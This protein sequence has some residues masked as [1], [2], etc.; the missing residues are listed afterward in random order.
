MQYIH[1]GRMLPTSFSGKI[2]IGHLV[3]SI[4]LPEDI[5]KAITNHY[6]SVRIVLAKFGIS[7]TINAGI[8][9]GSFQQESQQ[10]LT[11]ALET[12]L[13]DQQAAGS[14]YIPIAVRWDTIYSNG[15]HPMSTEAI[16]IKCK[17]EDI[18][19]VTTKLSNLYGSTVADHDPH[20]PLARFVSMAAL[21]SSEPVTAQ[22]IAWQ[23]QFLKSTHTANLKFLQPL[24]SILHVPLSNT[25]MTIA[26][27]FLG[28]RDSDDDC[29]IHTLVP[30][31]TR[32]DHTIM[33]ST[34]SNASHVRSIQ[35]NTIT[36]LQ[37]AYPWIKR[38]D[39]FEQQDQWT[40]LTREH[41][42][43]IIDQAGHAGKIVEELF[44]DWDDFPPLSDEEESLKS[45][46]VQGTWAIEP[47][48]NHA[49]QNPYNKYSK[50]RHHPK[51]KTCHSGSTTTIF[52]DSDLSHSS[53]SYSMCHSCQQAAKIHQADSTPATDCTLTVIPTPHN[54][55]NPQAIPA[56]WP[57]MTSLATATTDQSLLTSTMGDQLAIIQQQY[58]ELEEMKAHMQLVRQDL[59][60]YQ[61]TQVTMAHNLHPLHS[62][63]QEVAHALS[64]LT[65]KLNQFSFSPDPFTVNVSHH[66]PQESS[67]QPSEA[68]LGQPPK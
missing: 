40:P 67:H 39:I 11:N 37:Q 20:C 28:L 7:K 48:S 22:I 68:S 54:D 23:C 8:L 14:T 64:A 15:E 51:E 4:I 21:K 66:T 33:A 24:E 25:T 13:W 53:D 2:L 5:K 18:G 50:H 29:I 38:S 3:G 65:S 27:M 36:F 55:T 19:L 42:E 9:C 44:Q 43:I 49:R 63:V 32:K 31:G 61:A 1:Q 6:P 59:S 30:H 26:D 57:T 41:H 58:Q 46:P 60:Q 34:L 12:A 17:I 35:A 10:T 47:P 45:K 62:T 16:F 56:K 52:S